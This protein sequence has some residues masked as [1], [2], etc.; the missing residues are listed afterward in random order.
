MLT[1]QLTVTATLNFKVEAATAPNPEGMA[2]QVMDEYGERARRERVTRDIA[3]QILRHLMDEY[4][5]R[6][7]YVDTMFEAIAVA[8]GL[9]ADALG[10]NPAKIR[11]VATR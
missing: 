2:L 9:V 6:V 3:R 11:S 1:K 10:H 7:D 5:E 4:G 8:E